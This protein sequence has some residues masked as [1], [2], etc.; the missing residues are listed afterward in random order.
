MC[1]LENNTKQILTESVFV[2]GVTKQQNRAGCIL[3][4]H[5]NA[6]RGTS[7]NKKMFVKN[8]RAIRYFIRGSVPK[9]Y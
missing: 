3:R 1:L 6:R 2:Y 5:S 7:K 4:I 9:S 8:I